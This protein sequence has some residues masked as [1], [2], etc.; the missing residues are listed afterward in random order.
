MF[1][2]V[3]LNLEKTTFYV[4]CFFSYS[5]TAFDYSE[6]STAVVWYHLV[7]SLYTM[8]SE[9]DRRD[10]WCHLVLSWC[11]MVS[12]VERRDVQESRNIDYAKHH[13][14]HCCLPT[15]VMYP[16]DSSKHFS[17]LTCSTSILLVKN[18]Q[19]Y[20]YYIYI[21]TNIRLI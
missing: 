21:C 18:I 6:E 10:V 4:L 19:I 1:D 5:F 11:T 7:L 3:I 8:V 2:F 16:A 13:S 9:V 12:E 20:I 17:W 14:P 15:K